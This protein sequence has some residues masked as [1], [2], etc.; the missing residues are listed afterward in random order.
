MACFQVSRRESTP[1]LSVPRPRLGSL[2]T[3]RRRIG[4]TLVDDNFSFFLSPS[5]P[6][7]LLFSTPPWIILFFCIDRQNVECARLGSLEKEWKYIV[8]LDGIEVEAWKS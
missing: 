1:Y 8:S 6:L 2:L 7:L 5:P 3:K 4:A